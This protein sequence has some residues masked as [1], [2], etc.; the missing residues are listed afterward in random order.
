MDI[1]SEIGI[2][3]FFVFLA[4]A[5]MGIGARLPRGKTAAPPAEKPEPPDIA[6]FLALGEHLRRFRKDFAADA[7]REAED[8]A[9]ALR[10]GTGRASQMPLRLENWP[11]QV[12]ASQPLPATFATPAM[13]SLRGQLDALE[14]LLRAR[15]GLIRG[16]TAAQQEKGGLP[17]GPLQSYLRCAID[18]RRILDDILGTLD[19]I[20]EAAENASSPSI[21]KKHADAA[22]PPR[23]KKTPLKA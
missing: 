19:E 23:R 17:L 14:D 6:P 5:V 8:M 16:M 1:G 13:T 2:L 22:S 3:A 4:G 7:A 15:D 10:K 20:V 21:S 12:F 11:Q 18:T 9:L